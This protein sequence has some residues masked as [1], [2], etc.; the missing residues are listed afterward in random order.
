L[1]DIER[2]GTKKS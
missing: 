1:R 2:K